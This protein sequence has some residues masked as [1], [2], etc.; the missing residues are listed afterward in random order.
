MP[1]EL[2]NIK[3]S[4]GVLGGAFSLT[5]STII[6]KLLGVI[7]KIPLA[8]ILGEEGMG[9]FNSAY[10]VYA[11]FYLLCTAG[12]PKAVMIIISEAKARGEANLE[13]HIVKASFCAF[14]A[15]GVSVSAIFVVLANP[16]ARLIGNSLAAATMIA[17]AP[18]IIFISLSGVVR[19]YLSAGMN[20]LSIAVS[21]IIEGVGRLGVG[22]IFAILATRRALPLPIVSAFT[23]LGV[24]FGS[25]FGLIYLIITSKIKIFNKNIEQNGNVYKNS[26]VLRRIFSIS[27]PITL[28]ASVMSIT[29]VCDL[30]LIMRK[31]ISLGY[32][33]S[34]ATALY[35][36]YTTL[37][38]P[39][40]NLAIS[41]I[42]PISVAFM[43]IFTK[44][45]VLEDK[46]LISSSAK[47]SLELSA[48]LSAPLML[49]MMLYSR[50][51]LTMLF[52]NVGIDEG[53]PL[54]CLLAPG[55]FFMSVLL[56]TNSIL[57][58]HGYLKAPI[59]SMLI[60]STSKIIISYSLLSNAD[61]GISGAPIGTVVSYAIALIISLVLLIKK[62]SITL[63][64]IRAYI[65]PFINSTLS[66]LATRGLY[67]YL[68][69]TTNASSAL[70]A[71]ILSCAIIYAALTLI[72]GFLGKNKL[73][74]MAKYTNF[75]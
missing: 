32:T 73:K 71:V 63:P 3:S 13:K 22:L 19:G 12:V 5:L 56:I 8:R 39:M 48:L 17:I 20:L 53:A 74:E 58:A 35:G 26:F 66:I 10:T 50:E 69:N 23:I 75:A 41:I 42:T 67:N 54:L 43:P 51:I 28:G 15:L 40:F 16:L 6:V 21:Q 9:Y 70:L 46:R 59:I 57:E 36:N 61:Y 65:I 24:T 25:L 38:V 72:S 52:G 45:R 64:I 27:L 47:S 68:L 29:S 34:E 30:A 31:L 37:A 55:I 62:C 7:Y 60:G 44:A 33:A 4:S 18:S 49:G 14:L 2:K 11:I 1:S